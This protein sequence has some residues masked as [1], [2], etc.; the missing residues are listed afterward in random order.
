VR[1]PTYP[2]TPEHQRLL[3]GVVAHYADDNRVLAVSVFG[4]LG[5]G[6]WDEYSDLDLDVVIA[7][8]VTLSAPDEARRLCERLGQEPVVIVP[9][10]DDAADVVLASLMELSIRYHPLVS[11]SPNIVDSLLLLTGP[12]DRSAIVAAGRANRR[13]RLAEADELVGACVREAV[14]VDAMLHRRVFWLAYLVLHQGRERL[15]HLFAAS[16]DAQRPYH[17]FEAAADESLRA[18]LGRTLPRDDLPSLQRAFLALLD[19]LADHL[20]PLS[21]GQAGLTEAQR[22]TVAQLRARQARLDLSE[23][24]P[25]CR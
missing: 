17:A 19:V 7:D 18:H 20:G 16:H 10:R 14:T 12:L 25:S 22:Q 4:S 6:T 23:T 21:A 11:T 5:R 13:Q 1:S 3:R 9:D 8:E 24:S 15:L 2:G